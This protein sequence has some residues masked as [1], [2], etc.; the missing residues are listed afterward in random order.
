MMI[1]APIHKLVIK[2]AVPTIVSML[3]TSFY[4]MADTF[5]V[6]RIGTSATA[7]VGVVMPLMAIIQAIGFF[8]GQGSGN[9]ISRLMGARDSAEASR[10]ASTGFFTALACS[11]LF[12]GSLLL[13]VPK[14]VS[15]LGS[16]A[17][18][19]PYAE[20]YLRYILLGAPFMASSFVLNNQ[21]RLQGNASY[22]MVGITIGA[23]LNIGLDPLLIFGFKM[24]ITGA[25][26]ATS[27]SQF[28]SFCVLL[29]GCTRGGSV[30]IKLKDYSPNSKNLKEIAKAGLPSL[31]RQSLA[32]IAIVALN[33]SAAVY[34]D[35]AVAAM[36]IVGRLMMFATSVLLGFGQGFQP[37]CGFN[38]GARRYDR[39]L[40]AFWFCIKIG[41]VG[42]LLLAVTGE[43]FAPQIITAFRKDDLEVIRI[44]TRALRLQCAFFPL[45]SWVILCNMLTQN[46]GA[47]LSAS[48]LAFARQGLFFL[49]LILILPGIL[50]LSGVQWAQPAADACT[51]LLSVPIGYSVIRSLKKQMNEESKSEITQGEKT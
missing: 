23:V 11:V 36:S 33:V 6:G 37:V 20:S 21:L 24:G 4:N 5:F 41:A 2:M 28:V 38:Y 43:L 31:C 42:L 25:A 51:F 3:I 35:P 46:I 1:E 12:M 29:I 16:T 15:L 10:V 40:N 48:V 19:Q 17:T 32:S 18:I 49:P 13:A 26:V 7:A 39:V 30:P 34:G 50:G 14:I 9:Y 45:M 27:F 44:G 8:F 47:F 22:A